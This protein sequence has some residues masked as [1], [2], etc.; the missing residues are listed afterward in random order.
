LT[1]DR[2]LN[3]SGSCCYSLAIR[4][5]QYNGSRPHLAIAE[6]VGQMLSQTDPPMGE[7]QGREQMGLWEVMVPRDV[8]LED[9]DGGEAAGRC[10]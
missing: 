5:F 7:I 3:K 2:Q 9:S 6:P 8:R 1:L 10:H 4:C